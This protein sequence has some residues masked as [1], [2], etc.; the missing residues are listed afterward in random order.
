MY[1]A[2]KNSIFLKEVVSS[3]IGALFGAVFH[4]FIKNILYL[5]AKRLIVI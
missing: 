4:L 1:L 3:N 5:W 2:E